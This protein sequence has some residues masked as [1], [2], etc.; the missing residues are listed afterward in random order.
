WAG[1]CSASFCSLFQ[2][3]EEFLE[4][5]SG[6]FF[7]QA[8][9]FFLGEFWTL[10]GELVKRQAIESAAEIIPFRLDHLDG[11]AIAIALLFGLLEG[12]PQALDLS[13]FTREGRAVLLRGLFALTLM[14]RSLI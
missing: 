3:I 11:L 14:G 1:T 4:R 9:E 12:L 2:L 5:P 8:E 6:I 10:M 7:Y 13:G